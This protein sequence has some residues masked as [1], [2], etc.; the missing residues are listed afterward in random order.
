MTLHY[1]DFFTTVLAIGSVLITYAFATG[2]KLPVMNGSYRGWASI[3]LVTGLLMCALGSSYAMNEPGAWTTSWATFT[4]CLVA[5]ATL[6]AL[7]VIITG[8]KVLFWIESGSI[9][10]LWLT[11]T[12][13]HLFG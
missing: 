5:I 1:K 10:I 13:R 2:V 8:N 3:L 6:S 11:T 4:L 12:V 9:L 7:L